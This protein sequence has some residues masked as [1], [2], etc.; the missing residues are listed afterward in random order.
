MRTLEGLFKS[1][2]V[3]VLSYVF[4]TVLANIFVPQMAPMFNWIYLMVW[5]AFKAFFAEDV[6]KTIIIAA[7][8]AIIFGS[9][10]YKKENTIIGLI[11]GIVDLI[12]LKEQGH[13]IPHIHAHYQG[14]SISVSLLD[15]TVLAGNIP[16]KNE[17]IAVDYVLSHQNKLL[18]EW[19]DIHGKT[20]LPDYFKKR[21]LGSR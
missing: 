19:T 15:G 3:L 12:I 17:R 8:V 6:L 9:I 10:S 2:L 11:G 18:N 21:P 1:L 20:V 13:N 4:L 7:F 16:K 5:E 14:E